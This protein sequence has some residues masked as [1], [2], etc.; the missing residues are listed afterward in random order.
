MSD[1]SSRVNAEESYD[2]SVRRVLVCGGRNYNDKDKMFKY[3]SDIFAFGGIDTLITGGASGADS[4]A[5]EW[6]VKNGVPSCV[7]AANWKAYGKSA[8]PIRNRLML[9][10]GKPTHVLAFEGGKGTRNMISQAQ[11]AGIKV[12]NLAALSSSQS[13]GT[14][15]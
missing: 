8:G 13:E 12:I 5:H 10:H 14:N 6:G 3:L 15:D 2:S 4:L 11:K 1:N 9:T 7:Y